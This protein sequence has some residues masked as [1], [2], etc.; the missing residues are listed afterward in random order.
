[1]QCAHNKYSNAYFVLWIPDNHLQ[2]NATSFKKFKF[3]AKNV[4]GTVIKLKGNIGAMLNHKNAI[5][6]KLLCGDFLQISLTDGKEIL[7]CQPWATLFQALSSTLIAPLPSAFLL[8]F[9]FFKQRWLEYLLTWHLW[10]I[11]SVLQTW[12]LPVE[13]GRNSPFPSLAPEICGFIFNFV[14]LLIFLL[15]LRKTEY[16]CNC[17]HRADRICYYVVWES[18]PLYTCFLS[19][20]LGSS[21]FHVGRYKRVI[22]FVVWTFCFEPLRALLYCLPTENMKDKVSFLSIN[23]LVSSSNVNT[24]DNVQSDNLSSQN[25]H[26]LQ[27]HL[28]THKKTHIRLYSDHLFM[29]QYSRLY[30]S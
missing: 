9:S 10:C 11:N 20:H 21:P 14:L 29:S 13:S 22:F 5:L 27:W 23:F 19:L 1:M 24:K 18:S 30:F 8:S 28:C 2:W 17:T 26:R 12:Q 4:L 6:W 16:C 15:Y 25:S 7:R 3:I